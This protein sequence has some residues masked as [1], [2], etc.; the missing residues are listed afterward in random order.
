[1][2]RKRP[3]NP[4]TN[5]LVWAVILFVIL[6]GSVMILDTNPK[7]QR[8]DSF[9]STAVDQIPVPDQHMASEA[10]GGLKHRLDGAPGSLEQES[11][12]F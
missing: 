8:A 3:M 9:M 10:T 5:L 12:R 2:K 6:V 11:T 7:V 4:K 1:M